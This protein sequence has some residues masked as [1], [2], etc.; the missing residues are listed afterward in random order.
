VTD[1][2]TQARLQRIEQRV[3]SLDDTVAVLAMVDDAAAKQRIEE[4]FGNDPSMVIVYRG[5]QRNI[6]Q[7]KTAEELRARHL[8]RA[9]QA[10]VSRARALLE[11]KGF[12][13]KG[14][15]R[16][17]TIRDGWAPFGIE[18]YLRRVLRSGGIADLA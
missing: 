7:E 17:Y 1:D 16:G 12:L 18:R 3:A 9:N 13:R 6:T 8:P 4:T 11:D 15:P 14:E 2:H 10:E 5:V